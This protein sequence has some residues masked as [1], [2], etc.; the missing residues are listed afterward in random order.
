MEVGGPVRV[1][2]V[3]RLCASCPVLLLLYDTGWS[4]KRVGKKKKRSHDVRGGESERRQESEK[5]TKPWR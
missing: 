4:C 2:C 5:T 1:G 3:S